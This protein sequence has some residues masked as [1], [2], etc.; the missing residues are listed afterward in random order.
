MIVLQL[1][2]AAK[3][4]TSSFKYDQSLVKQKRLPIIMKV[5]VKE[6]CIKLLLS[7][8]KVVLPKCF[9]LFWVYLSVY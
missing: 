1:L 3:S 9:Y 6:P 7:T 5:D 8:V 2:R 4:T